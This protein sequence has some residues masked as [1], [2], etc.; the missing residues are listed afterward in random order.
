MSSCGS[1]HIIVEVFTEQ[2]FRIF[3]EG[4]YRYFPMLFV[5]TRFFI[6]A[7]FCANNLIRSFHHGTTAY[8][9]RRTSIHK[10][11][12]GVIFTDRLSFRESVHSLHASSKAA[13]GAIL[14]E[15]IKNNAGSR[16]SLNC[17][18]L[19][20]INFCLRA[21]DNG[22][23]GPSRSKLLNEITN[24]VF[25]NIMIGFEPAIEATLLR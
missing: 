12:S 1:E 18:F 2:L 19:G 6:L 21:S 15:Q 22:L 5:F 7:S 9:L 3:P 4:V 14:I 8:G 20:M 24:V 16:S 10:P 11:S 25:K 23:S 17:D 13:A